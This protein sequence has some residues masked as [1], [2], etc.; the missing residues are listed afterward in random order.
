MAVTLIDHAFL[1]GKR[2]VCIMPVAADGYYK[3]CGKMAIL[4]RVVKVHV[5]G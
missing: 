2:G 3:P 1:P 4:H 5:H